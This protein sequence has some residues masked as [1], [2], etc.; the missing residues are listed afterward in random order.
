MPY[1][2]HPGDPLTP[3][4]ASHLLIRAAQGEPLQAVPVKQDGAYHLAHVSTL[5]ADQQR[6]H[7]QLVGQVAAY[8][9]G[10]NAPPLSA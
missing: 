10:L 9:L 3:A 6:E 4:E 8:L 5:T 1:H 2:K 7:A